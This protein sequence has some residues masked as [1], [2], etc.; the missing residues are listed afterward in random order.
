[1]NRSAIALGLIAWL[2][3]GKAC[4]G[5]EVWHVK[6]TL[7]MREDPK[8]EGKTKV[9]L[10]LREEQTDEI[11]TAAES[12]PPQLR[13]TWTSSKGAVGKSPA[14]PTALEGCVLLLETKE[15]GCSATVE[16]GTPGDNALALLTKGPPDPVQ[17]FLPTGEVKQG[18]TW[19]VDA[20]SVARF[21]ASACAG[22]AGMSG[23]VGGQVQ[24]DVSDSEGVALQ[25]KVASI[26][27]DEV[28][29][30]FEG[31]GEAKVATGIEIGGAE[32]SPSV[33]VEISGSLVFSLAKRRPLKL[34]W[35][36]TR[37]MNAKGT[38][39]VAPGITASVWRF[40]GTRSITRSY[41]PGK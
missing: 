32:G 39:K 22:L 11:L 18:T 31:K 24:T 25:A 35:A 3:T 1:M 19:Q 33:W 5:D 36:E 6:Q 9:N 14:Q 26:R 2:A 15:E 27:G 21:L 16:K 4:A 13:R 12:G 34:Q 8:A 30:R 29:V 41:A 38:A 40:T 28:T 23:S 20:P 7:E 37:A 10:A 17:L